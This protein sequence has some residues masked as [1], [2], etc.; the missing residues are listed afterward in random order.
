MV[1]GKAPPPFKFPDNMKD[2][3]G[4]ILQMDDYFIITQ[5]RNEIQRLAY[6]TRYTK[7]D[8]LK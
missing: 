3:E 4:W 5:T 1:A 7:G 8:A 6:V 2:L